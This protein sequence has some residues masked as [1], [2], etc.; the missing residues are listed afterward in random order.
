MGAD[1]M[2]R[3]GHGS[4]K[5]GMYADLRRD[6][7]GIRAKSGCMVRDGGGHESAAIDGRDGY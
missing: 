3:V 5:A 6:G 4:V 1:D 2:T 7:V